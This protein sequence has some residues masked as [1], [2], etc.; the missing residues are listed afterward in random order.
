MTQSGSYNVSSFATSMEAEIRRLNSQVDLF[1]V[2]ESPILQRYGLRDGMDVLDCGCGPGRL[3]E[4]LKGQMPG[5]R[6]TGL[7]MD[8]V[9]VEAASLLMEERGLNGCRIVQ[10]TAEQ[11][12]LGEASFDFIILRLV[13]EH[14]PDPLLALR[15][16][17]RLLRLGGR[18]VIIDNDF[19]FHLRTW[20]PV[21][22]LDPLY[23]AYCA[24]RRNDGGDPCIGRR[25]PRYLEQAELEVIGYEIE[26]A[27]NAVLGDIPFLRAE[28]AGIP[29]QLV[30]T[31]FL[32]ASTLEE[33]TRSWKAMLSEPGHSIVRPLFIG[34]GEKKAEPLFSETSLEKHAPAQP[35]KETGAPL[36]KGTG[37]AEETLATILALAAGILSE[38]LEEVGK[39][40]IEPGDSLMDLGA[41]SLAALDLQE[42][43]KNRTSIEI[44]LEKLLGNVSLDNLAKHVDAE[45][46]KRGSKNKA[47]D[48]P[49]GQ[50]RPTSWNEGEI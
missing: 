16:L 19:E 47:T 9:L 27:H 37:E 13:L 2:L 35:T 1:W 36:A 48:G 20:P 11:P 38:K 25:L 18:I 28:G 10:G 6:C 12:G 23:E 44:P 31:G 49:D 46:A 8:P 30:N 32:D 17:A 3:I 45:L 39:K 7:E 21:P 40:R 33:M 26:I 42:K 22:Q 15:S 14:V 34:I 24:S 43:I 4:L 5:L 41:D 29:A 50:K